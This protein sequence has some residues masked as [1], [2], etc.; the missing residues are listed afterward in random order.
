MAIYSRYVMPSLRFHLSVHNIHQTHLDKLDHLAKRYLKTWLKFPTR[1][2]TDLSIFHPYMLGVK[3]PSQVYLEG[4]AGNYLNSVVRGDP[5][6]QEALAVGV[7]REEVWT[8]KSSTICECRDIFT[9]VEES[10]FVPTPMNTYHLNTAS[11]LSLPTL[12]KRNE[13][14]YSKEILRQIQ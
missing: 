4:H 2:V 8:R 13:Y 10:C 6:V 12:K 7:A 14:N 11:R 9:E 3:P 5:V 1:G